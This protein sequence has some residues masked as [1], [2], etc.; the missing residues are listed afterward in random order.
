MAVCCYWCAYRQLKYSLGREPCI[1]DSECLKQNVINER[2]KRSGRNAVSPKPLSWVTISKIII[3]YIVCRVPICTLTQ[4]LMCDYIRIQPKRKLSSS[5]LIL[6]PT[7]LIFLHL[8]TFSLI[9]Q[10]SDETKT[11]PDFFL[12][13]HKLTVCLRIAYLLFS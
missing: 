6:P 2:K 5:F 13:W 7:I 1:T 8:F 10:T 12:N 3:S 11:V 9:V 4:H